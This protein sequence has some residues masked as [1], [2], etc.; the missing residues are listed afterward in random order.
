MESRVLLRRLQSCCNVG[1][2]LRTFMAGAPHL[3]SAA[4]VLAALF[5]L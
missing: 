3:N 5:I 4:S 1:A 2:S